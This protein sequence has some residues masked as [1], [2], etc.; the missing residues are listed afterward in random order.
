MFW[1]YSATGRATMTLCRSP[2][3]RVMSQVATTLK[4]ALILLDILLPN[5]CCPCLLH[6][7]KSPSSS[8]KKH[9]YSP[10][11]NL[12]CNGW[13]AARFPG[14]IIIVIHSMSRYRTI[15]GRRR[16]TSVLQMSHSL[17]YCIRVVIESLSAIPLGFIWLV[18]LVIMGKCYILSTVPR[19]SGVAYLFVLRR[20]L[21]FLLKILRR[22]SEKSA[23]LSYF[24]NSIFA[25]QYYY[26]D[27][28]QF[29][30]IFMLHVAQKSCQP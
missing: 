4:M 26:E 5:F 15:I 20:M 13:R 8:I 22:T 27:A 29:C 14:I 2:Q 1:Q 25:M 6:F 24:C 16:R 10:R 21:I 9:E 23:M 3:G 19:A 18:F 12:I 7:H 28:I 30:V 17:L 11:P